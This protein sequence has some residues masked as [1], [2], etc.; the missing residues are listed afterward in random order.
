VWFIVEH[1]WFTATSSKESHNIMT[2]YNINNIIVK[3]E[4][5]PHSA[6]LAIEHDIMFWIRPL[7]VF[8]T[9]RIF[10]WKAEIWPLS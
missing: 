8:L 1:I 4:S 10:F 5:Q 2:L 6:T 7:Q 9:A 3:V